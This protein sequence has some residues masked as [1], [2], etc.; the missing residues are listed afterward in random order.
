MLVP[1]N[2]TGGSY[3]H[4]STQ[5]SAQ[6]CVNLWPQPQTNEKAKSP[7]ILESYPGKS[8]FGTQAGGVDRGMFEHGEVLYKITGT[9]LY[10]VNSSGTH[11]SVGTIPGTERCIFAPIGDDLVI[12]NGSARYFADVSVP[13]VALISDANL[14]A[15]HGIA[16]LNSQIIY[17]GAAGRFGV[18]DAGVATSID[19]LNYATAEADA[20]GLV[21]PYTFGQVAQMLGRK[22]GELWWNSGQGNPPLERFEGGVIQKGLGAFHSVANDDDSIYILAN[23]FAVFT[24]AGGSSAVIEP[25]TP[26]TIARTFRE[27][28]TKSDAIGWCMNWDGQ[29][30]YV[31]TFPTADKTWAHAK[32]GEWFELSSGVAGGRDIANSYAFVYGKHLV[33]DYRNG[34]I[35]QLDDDV[36]DDNGAVLIRQRDSAP[37]HG[38]LQAI[39]APG[40]ELVM[41]SF[42]L[43]MEK[44]VGL[45]TGQGS[46]PVVMLS[47]SDDGGETFSNEIYMTVGKS[48]AFNWKAEAFCLGRF[49]SRIIRIRMSDPVYWSIHAAAANIEV[50]I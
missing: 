27:Y 33:A 15:G 35:Y 19:A 3:T 5:L 49:Y 45:L 12:D 34:N 47:F 40:K 13:S 23:D 9:V 37:L 25:I 29:W 7:Y 30:V 31:L 11:T 1:I 20:D 41:N 21:R 39:G 50:C 6:S 10:S 48:G 14:E 36:Y 26:P 18:S 4:K 8:L 2:L 46:D 43:I 22:T 28:S 24:L 16:H 17:N 42:E 32:G 38:G 44:G